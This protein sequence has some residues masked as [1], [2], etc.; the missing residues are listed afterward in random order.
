MNDGAKNLPLPQG[1]TLLGDFFS[2]ISQKS[3]IPVVTVDYKRTAF[4]LHLSDVRITIDENIKA[5][6]YKEPFDGSTPKLLLPDDGLSILEVKYTAGLPDMIRSI[7]SQY[8]MDR[9]SIS[10]Y[11]MS[12]EPFIE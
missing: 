11:V 5:C 6:R 8:P 3:L 12:L 1:K 10:K 4:M 9:C 7:L 2:D